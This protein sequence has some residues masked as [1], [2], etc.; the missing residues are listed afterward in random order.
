M[1]KNNWMLLLARQKKGDGGIL[2]PKMVLL[3]PDLLFT[4]VVIVITYFFVL[5]IIL[6]KTSVSDVESTILAS[7]AHNS[8]EGF[9]LLDAKLDRVYPGVVDPARFT[10]VNLE[11]L[12][13]KENPA[14]VGRFVKNQTIIDHLRQQE[15]KLPGEPVRCIATEAGGPVNCAYTNQKKFERWAPYARVGGK[16]EGSVK[17]YA[18]VRYVDTAGGK[19]AV[20]ETVFLAAS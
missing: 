14:I 6:T 15:A 1:K 2:S 17:P 9:S 3:I 10:T 8:K 12:F 13:A 4:V 16:G 19:G 11:S 5:S 7:Y 20:V 18:E